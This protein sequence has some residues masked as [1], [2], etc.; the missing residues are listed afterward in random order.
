MDGH[1]LEARDWAYRIMEE[2]SLFWS[3]RGKTVDGRIFL[4]PDYNQPMEHQREITMQRILYLGSRGMFDGWLTSGREAEMKRF[5]LLESAGI[6][7]HSLTVKIGVHF[8]L[9]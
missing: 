1:D 4:I 3:P 7:D 9:W 6:F 5:A 8:F 2:S